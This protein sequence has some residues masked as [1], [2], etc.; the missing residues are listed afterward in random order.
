[1]SFGTLQIDKNGIFEVILLNIIL[2]KLV[3]WKASY[4]E[5]SILKQIR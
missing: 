1:M 4:W 2:V 3:L 5:V